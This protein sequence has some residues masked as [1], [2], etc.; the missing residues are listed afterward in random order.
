MSNWIQE[1]PAYTI[2][3][4]TIIVATTTWFVSSFVIDENKVNLYKAR[5]ENADAISEQYKAKISVLELELARLRG[6]NERYLSW[7]MQEPRAIPALESKI[8]ALELRLGSIQSSDANGRTSN[9][10]VIDAK[11]LPYE[12]VSPFSKGESFVDPRTKA[13]LGIFD[14]NPDYTA[15]GVLYLPGGEN[16][17]LNNVKPGAT[18]IFE[19]GGSNYKMTLEGVNWI[20]NSLKASVVELEASDKRGSEV[21]TQP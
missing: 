4:H 7:L 20:S 10:P 13:T 9:N 1:H 8:K 21:K 6:E 5:A 19:Q 16:V 17:E 3:G 11:K 15:E 12:F 2:I 14:I 18:W